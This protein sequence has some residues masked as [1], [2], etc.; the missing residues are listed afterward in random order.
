MEPPIIAIMD[1]SP[2]SALRFNLTF[3]KKEP[4]TSMNIKYIPSTDTII[5][6]ENTNLPEEKNCLLTRIRDPKDTSQSIDDKTSIESN[7][8]TDSSDSDTPYDDKSSSAES[9]D[10]SRP[11]FSNLIKS[12][13]QKRNNVKKNFKKANKNVMSATSSNSGL[14]YKSNKNVRLNY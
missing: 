2:N 3:P 5:H 8:R 4:L 14:D 12:N 7:S 6:P 10:Q 1:R 9:Y 11:A 13:G